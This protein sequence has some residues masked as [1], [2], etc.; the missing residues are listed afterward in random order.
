MSRQEPKKHL[1]SRSLNSEK[2]DWNNTS[3]NS[4]QSAQSVHHKSSNTDQLNKG[5]TKTV[6]QSERKK[7]TEMVEHVELL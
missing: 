3:S 4:D 2:N 7:V 5:N 6:D 1:Y